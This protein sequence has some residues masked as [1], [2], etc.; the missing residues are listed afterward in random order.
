M[1]SGFKAF[2]LKP[3]AADSQT[4]ESSKGQGN[5]SKASRFKAKTALCFLNA[6][7]IYISQEAFSV[8]QSMHFCQHPTAPHVAGTSGLRLPRDRTA[9]S[10]SLLNGSKISSFEGGFN[11]W[12][13]GIILGQEKSCPAQECHF[14]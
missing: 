2:P 1:D 13:T 8:S 9:H 11:L 12:E 3:K 5:T 7:K 14:G 10:Q 4:L 6:D